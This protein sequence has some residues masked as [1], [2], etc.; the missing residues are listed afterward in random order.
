MLTAKYERLSFDITGLPLS[1][2]MMGNVAAPVQGHYLIQAFEV[3]VNAWAT[4]HVRLTVNYVLN[5]LDGDS[6]QMRSNFYFDRNEHELLFRVGA[7]L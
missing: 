3:G 6:A 1:V 7:N 2:G 5:H 4:K